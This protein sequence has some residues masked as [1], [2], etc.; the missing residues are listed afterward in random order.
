[1]GDFEAVT[2]KAAGS[3]GDWQPRE[4]R[5]QASRPIQMRENENRGL[6]RPRFLFGTRQLK[7]RQRT[8]RHASPL[9]PD[10]THTHLPCRRAPFL[11]HEGDGSARKGTLVVLHVK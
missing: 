5:A 6:S 11:T 9:R 10:G 1:S 8:T 3:R 4:S 2:P 7:T